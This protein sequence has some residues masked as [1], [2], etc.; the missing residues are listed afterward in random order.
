MSHALATRNLMTW[1]SKVTDKV[2]R[3]LVRYLTLE[4]IRRHEDGEELDDIVKSILMDKGGR[5]RGLDAGEFEAE[6]GVLLDAGSDTTAIALTHAV[7]H[8]LRTPKALE[9]LREEV[10]VALAPHTIVASYDQVKSLRYLSACLDESM[11]LLPPV[12]FGLNRKTGPEGLTVDGQ[13]IPGGVTVA[14]PAYTAHHNPDI[15]PDPES[16]YPDR[17]LEDDVKDA[18]AAFIPFSAGARGPPV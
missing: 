1:E 7:Y 13:W 8:L 6:V 17:W 18:R 2:E 4:R 11:R 16:Y 3:L 5:A 14:V 12:S 15:F 9:R 10:D